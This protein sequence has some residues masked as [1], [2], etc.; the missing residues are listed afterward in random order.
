[1]QSIKRILTL[2]IVSSVFLLAWILNDRGHLSQ[3]TVWTP[4]CVIQD[5]SLLLMPSGP[6]Q[7]TFVTKNGVTVC[8]IYR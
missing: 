8:V 7:K 2:V 4:I 3:R 5:K 6:P 1:M